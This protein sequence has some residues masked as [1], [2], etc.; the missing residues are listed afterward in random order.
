MKL[1]IKWDYI[2][3]DIKSNDFIDKYNEKIDF[4]CNNSIYIN[5][6]IFE[7]YKDKL[8]WIYI[9]SSRK[10]SESFIENHSEY[11][12]WY[13]IIDCQKLSEEVIE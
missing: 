9:S 1:K 11:I 4:S 6:Y 8:D 3:I 12:D 7:K 10:L 5:K 13:R 2:K